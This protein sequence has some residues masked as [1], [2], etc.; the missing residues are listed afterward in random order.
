METKTIICPNCG[1]TT[2]RTDHCE[3]CGSFLVEKVSKGIDVSAYV[4]SVRE[5]PMDSGLTKVLE[6]YL[7]LIQQ[8]KGEEELIW[9]QIYTINDNDC[10]NCRL[11]GN[12]QGIRLMYYGNWRNTHRQFE[13]SL[14]MP[15]FNRYDPTY[16]DDIPGDWWYLDFGNDVQGAV[17]L[18]SQ[19]LRE[20]YRLSFNDI[21]YK[22]GLAEIGEI[23]DDPAFHEHPEEFVNENR[24]M[25]TIMDGKY[26][27]CWNHWDM[28][29]YAKYNKAGVFL[30]GEELGANQYAGVTSI[31]EYLRSKIEEEEREHEEEEKELREEERQQKAAE[32]KDK[33]ITNRRE[34]LDEAIFIIAM[35]GYGVGIVG[36]GLVGLISESWAPLIWPIAIVT[37]IIVLLRIIKA[38]I[39]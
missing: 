22:I 18:I 23:Y 37:G 31:S 12:N 29:D 16:T 20:V 25:Y 7:S 9:L 13:N 1:A 6:K 11:S 8:H 28:D 26:E 39:K 34:G 38:S 2:N 10:L 35:M 36:G 17:K 21:Y 14:I 3:F 33:K 19:F 15:L 30:N 32:E 5:I 24:P 4:D 27:V